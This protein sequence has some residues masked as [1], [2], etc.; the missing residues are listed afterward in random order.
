[1]FFFYAVLFHLMA[2]GASKDASQ[3]TTFQIVD[4]SPLKV[5]LKGKDSLSMYICPIICL[6]TLLQFCLCLQ[7]VRLESHKKHD[8]S[9]SEMSMC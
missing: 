4:N 6:M 5:H 9:A 3:E 2:L 7:L 8:S 1:M